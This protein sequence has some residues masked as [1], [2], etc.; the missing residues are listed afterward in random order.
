MTDKSAI[1]AIRLVEAVNDAL[2]TSLRALESGAAQGDPDAINQIVHIAELLGGAR[3]EPDETEAVISALGGVV[4]TSRPAYIPIR[5]LDEFLELKRVL[6]RLRGWAELNKM[7]PGEM[8]RWL[9]QVVEEVD[10]RWAAR[11]KAGTGDE[12]LDL[13]TQVCADIEAG[14]IGCVEEG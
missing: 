12:V 2:K 6:P 10:R 8:L 7:S 4:V 1:S 3:V 13:I 5:S 14:R 11:Q 9:Y